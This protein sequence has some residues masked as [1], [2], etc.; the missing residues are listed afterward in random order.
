MS[1]CFVMIIDTRFIP[2]NTKPRIFRFVKNQNIRTL[3][4]G[5]QILVFPSD[6]FPAQI[7]GKGV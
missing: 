5:V 3:H 1:S 6:V 4:R 7:V 2:K